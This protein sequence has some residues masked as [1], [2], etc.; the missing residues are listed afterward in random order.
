MKNIRVYKLISGE[1]L[2]GEVFNQYDQY[3][4]LKNPAT[5]IMQQNPNGNVG[6]GLMPFMP[7]SEGNVQL[8]K[9]AIAGEATPSPN[10]VN[11]YNRIF[12]SGIQVAP[13]SALASL[14]T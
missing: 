12:G 13:A 5:I 11:E 8:N 7:Y 2:I 3:I 6:I 4:D 14:K 1:E 10:M 9:S